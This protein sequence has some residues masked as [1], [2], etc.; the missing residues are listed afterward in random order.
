MIISQ[1]VGGLGNQMFLYAL[2]KSVALKNKTNFKVDKSEFLKYKLHK[3]SLNNLSAETKI[4]SSVEIFLWKKFFKFQE[5][6]FNFDKK[7]FLKK[8]AYFVGYYQSPKYFEWIRED[9][10]RDF[11]PKKAICGKNFD[12]AKKIEKEN[13][14]S[15]HVRR[16]DYVSNKITKAKH[17]VC[18]LNYYTQAV[19]IIKKKVKQPVFY[20]FSDDKNWVK[21]NIKTKSP[22]VFVDWN[23]ADNSFEDMRLISLCKH[24]I[25]A[26]STFSWWGAWLNKNPNKI[27]IAPQKWFAN[28]TIDT[29]DLIP[30]SWFRL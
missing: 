16:G 15:L 2:G 14:V 1:I 19:E 30:H 12:A 4:A 18:S 28:K 13:S 21:K 5:K 17:G 20:I 26:N 27:V 9:I 25:I 3:Y 11:S 6:K 24:N 22:Q 29:S 7:V 23:N 10:I 8:N